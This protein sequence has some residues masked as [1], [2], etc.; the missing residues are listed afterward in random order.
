MEQILPACPVLAKEEYIKRHDAVCIHLHCNI[1]KETGV[2][3]DNEHSYEHVR[4]SAEASHE[5]KVTILWNQQVRNDRT[6]PSNKPDITIRDNK[7]GTCMLID[8]AIH[9]DRNVIKKDAENILKCKDLII[10]IQRMWNVKT[11][12]VPVTKGASGTILNITQTITEQHTRK[13][14]NEGNTKNS[15]V[16]RRT[17]TAESANVKVQNILHGRNDIACSTN[18]NY[19]TA[20]TLYTIGRCFVRGTQ[21]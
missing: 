3:S 4:K 8:N 11:K 21:L 1:C 14:R 20:A 10:E 17:H 6:I 19:R 2:K 7:R 16:G 18:C 15:P 12:V 9:G 5:G 13:A